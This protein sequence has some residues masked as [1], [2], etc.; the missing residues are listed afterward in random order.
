MFAEAT[1]FLAVSSIVSTLDI[2]KARDSLGQEIT[3]ELS[4][5]SGLVRQVHTCT[6]S[7]PGGKLNPAA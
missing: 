4:F 7:R 1:V 5:Q 3:P 2:K 6:A